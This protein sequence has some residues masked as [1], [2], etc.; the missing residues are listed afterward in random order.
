M[1]K[2]WKR[3]CEVNKIDNATPER[4]TL[5]AVEELGEYAET[6]HWETGYKKTSKSKKEIKDDQLQ[7]GVD[8][9]IC[10]LASLDKQGNSYS[11]I[12]KMF[13]KKITKW[14]KKYEGTEV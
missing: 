1:K 12:K 9:I 14:A 6:I 5:K 10:I 8:V 2:I 13:D 3:I 7:E 11:D 4:L